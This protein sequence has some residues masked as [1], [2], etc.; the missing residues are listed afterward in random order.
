MSGKNIFYPQISTD[1]SP[2]MCFCLFPVYCTF[3]SWNTQAFLA[4]K[5][6]RLCGQDAICGTSLAEFSTGKL[7]I[8]GEIQLSHFAILRAVGR[9]GHF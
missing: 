3:S 4:K 7:L 5:A 8:H 9:A 2:K 1:F 6:G